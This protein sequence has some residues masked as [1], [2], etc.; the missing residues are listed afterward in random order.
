[1]SEFSNITSSI[2][3]NTV[4]KI[5]YIHFAFYLIALTHPIIFAQSAGSGF[6]V[7]S[8]TGGDISN[9]KLTLLK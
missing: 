3:P 5:K 9:Q 6:S 7:R 1:M 4:Q 8:V 2:A